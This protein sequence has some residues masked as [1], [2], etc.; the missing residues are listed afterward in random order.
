M[1]IDDH[2]DMGE[3]RTHLVLTQPAHGLQPVHVS[4][5]LALLMRPTN[6]AGSHDGSRAGQT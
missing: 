1:I 2:A 6:G 4:R 5:A 3:L